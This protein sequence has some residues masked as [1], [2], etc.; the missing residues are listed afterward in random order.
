M[1]RKLP[2]FQVFITFYV[3]SVV[4]ITCICYLYFSC[5]YIYYLYTVSFTI[6]NCIVLHSITLV[7]CLLYLL[8]H[9]C[10]CDVL[11]LTCFHIQLSVDRCWSCEMY[12]RTYVCMCIYIYMCV[13]VCKHNKTL[14][15]AYIFTEMS[16][17]QNKLFLL[18]ICIISL[19]Q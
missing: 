11:I 9:S 10:M 14:N 4:F 7:S 1:T 12:V 15:S 17:G 8:C 5:L 19:E 6:V 3:Y 2:T 13:C 16:G 18:Y